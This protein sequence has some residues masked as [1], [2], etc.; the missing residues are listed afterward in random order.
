[1]SQS[2]RALRWCRRNPALASVSGL[3]ALALVAVVVVSI[4]FG[5]NRSH[6][7]EDQAKAARDLASA[8]KDLEKQ[9][10]QL[11][12]TLIALKKT[13][14][15]RRQALRKTSELALAKGML[16]LDNQ[17]IASGMLWLARALEFAP[18]DDNDLQW[19]VHP[20]RGLE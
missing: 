15:G 18:P 3:A 17:E 19:Y 7:A 8:N 10:Q 14:Q 9:R 1:M 2:E 20:A 13:D 12:D 5:I 4:A 11:Q 6:Y 16:L